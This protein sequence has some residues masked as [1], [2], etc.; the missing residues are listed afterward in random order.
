[1]IAFLPALASA[2]CIGL[3]IL[4][5]RGGAHKQL[6]LDIP[7][8][9]SMHNRPM[10]RYGGIGIVAGILTTALVLWQWQLALVIVLL[11]AVSWIDDLGHVPIP[12]RLGIQFVVAIAWVAFLMPSDWVLRTVAIFT[13][14]WMTNLYNFMDGA[15]GLAG[16]M[17]LIGFTAYGVSAWLAGN[18]ILAMLALSVAASAGGFLLF[19]FP[20]AKIFMGDVGSVPLGFIAGAIGLWGWQ[21]GMWS[22]VFPLVVFLPFILDATVTLLT[23]VWRRKKFWQAHH[24]H[25]YQRL[26][27]LGWSQSKLVRSE[28]FLMS[29]M[30]LSALLMRGS[31]IIIQWLVL[32]AWLIA[33]F[34]LMAAVNRLWHRFEQNN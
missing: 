17:A 21:E 31:D 22:P 14:V 23:R 4:F 10:P 6:A 25:Y 15:D 32:G 7:N 12:V 1:M 34:L 2:V 3:I 8:E 26:V 9:R 30:C 20:P 29:A 18:S 5:M 24:D 16:G 11:A 27:R 28:Y 33:C 13:L 19:N